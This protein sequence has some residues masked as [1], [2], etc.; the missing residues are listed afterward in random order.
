V[1]VKMTPENGEAEFVQRVDVVM[2][3][4]KEWLATQAKNEATGQLGP[5]NSGIAA[6]EKVVSKAKPV[7]KKPTANEPESKT[8]PKVLNKI[9]IATNPTPALA[10]SKAKPPVVKPGLVKS[11]PRLVAKV[12]PK[13]KLLK[14]NH[15]KIEKIPVCQSPTPSTPSPRLDMDEVM[16]KIQDLKLSD[17]R[18]STQRGTKES[19]PRHVHSGN[20]EVRAQEDTPSPPTPARPTAVKQSGQKKAAP[21]LRPTNPVPAV[22]ESLSP[23]F[24]E[25]SSDMDVVKPTKPGAVPTRRIPLRMRSVNAKPPAALIRASPQRRKNPPRLV[26]VTTN[27]KSP[28]RRRV[29]ITRAVAGR[30]EG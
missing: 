26:N 7:P 15:R 5:V 3:P 24:I 30:K 4:Y 9:A 11:P 18:L 14:P 21:K 12:E 10:K 1:K 20:R 8:R 25:I 23:E 29:M 13:A 27:A 22:K 19:D 28:P 6:R 2:K 16:E 17:K